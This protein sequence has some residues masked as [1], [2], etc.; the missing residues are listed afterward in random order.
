[1]LIGGGLFGS[2]IHDPV[3][4]RKSGKTMENRP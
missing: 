2:L 3:I 4:A 1:L